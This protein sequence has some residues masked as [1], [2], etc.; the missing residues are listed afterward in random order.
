MKYLPFE[1]I[2]YITYLSEVKVI[3]RLSNQLEQK[4]RSL[5]EI[6]F[7]SYPNKPYTGKIEGNTFKMFRNIRYSNSFLPRITGEIKK[8]IQGTRIEVKMQLHIFVLIFIS[9]WMGGVIFACLATLLHLFT[10][11]E[12]NIFLLVPF[13][14]FVFGYGLTMVGFK[15][16][17]IKS[18]K[19]L[20]KLFK[21]EIE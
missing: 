1:D 14:M 16:E 18:K 12:F 4:K 3:E 7:R 15:S 11:S 6:I 21:A 9:L 20:A 2:V 17:S 13:A 10:S 8:D 5:K 19:F